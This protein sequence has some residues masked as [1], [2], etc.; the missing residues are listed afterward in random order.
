MKNELGLRNVGVF[1]RENIWLENSLSQLA[2]AIL[3]T[4][5]GCVSVRLR[6][7]GFKSCRG[8][9]CLSLVV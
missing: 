2:Q 5:P 7:S 6:D 4:K 1:I 8:H 3:E 9:G